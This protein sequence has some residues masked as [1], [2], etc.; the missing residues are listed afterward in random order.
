M[1][2]GAKDTAKRPR[3]R[4]VAPASLPT[5]LPRHKRIIEAVWRHRF[6]T[7]HQIERLDGGSSDKLRRHLRDLYAAAYLE[8][9]NLPHPYRADIYGI[10]NRGADY[11]AN[12][13]GVPRKRI[14]YRSRMRDW[15]D[16]RQ[17]EHT[18]LAAELMI[19][20]ELAA[21]SLPSIEYVDFSRILADASPRAQRDRAPH[22]WPAP[23]E[24]KGKRYEER[25]VPDRIFGLRVPERGEGYFF[26]ESD[27][28]SETVVPSAIYGASFLKKILQ[29]VATRDAW[30]EEGAEP[31][32]GFRAFRVLTV[33]AG[34]QRAENLARAVAPATGG[35]LQKMFLFTHR[36]AI[37]NADP[38]AIGWLRAD[39]QVVKLLED[40]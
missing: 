11:M 25:I 31:W 2:E 24:W 9:H 27:T 14:D 22:S 23:F 37:E 29:Y 7:S 18:L 4:R 36:D 38:L 32:F 20:F 17:L 10:G 16:Q 39:G 21:R 3:F 34:A 35:R 15:K 13:L 8:K 30:R 5:L 12:A 1:M 6:L 28:G 40:D 33:T 26:V 19:G